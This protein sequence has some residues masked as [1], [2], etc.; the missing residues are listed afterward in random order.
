MYIFTPVSE[1]RCLDDVV[2][3]PKYLT[4]T[5]WSPCC[6]PLVNNAI[7]IFCVLTS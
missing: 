5:T 1:F 4:V 2:M 6:D 3:T 7:L